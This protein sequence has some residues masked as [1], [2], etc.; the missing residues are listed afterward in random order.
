[1]ANGLRSRESWG[2]RVGVI[3][4]VTGSAVG[5][6]NFLR[7]PGLAAKYEGGAFMIPYF[8]ALLVLGLPLAWG[9]WAMG[10]FGGSRG[11]NSTPGIY[12]SIWKRK[13]APY[14]G[15]LGLV[16]PVAIYMYYV[17]VESWCLGYAWHYLDGSMA[18]LGKVARAAGDGTVAK[19]PYVDLFNHF[20][21]ATADGAAFYDEGAP[22]LWFLL[23]CVAL[24]F[25]LIYR[26]L[27]KG[28]ERFCLIAMPALVVCALIVLVRVLTLPNVELGLGFMWN[29]RTSEGGF[30][31]SLLNADMWMAATSQI[32]FS[33]SVGFGVII[34]YSSYLKHDDDIALSS[35]TS[36]AGNEFCEVALGG[37]ITIPAAFIFLGAATVTQASGSSFNLGFMT[38][39]MVF[40]SMQFGYTV[41]FLFFFLLFLA[42][43]T[44]SLSMLQPAIALLEEGLG[45][46]RRAS[47]SMLGFITL[48]GTGFVLYFSKDNLALGMF[49]FWV[50]TFFIFVLALLQTVLFGW[51]LGV[52]RG[53]EELRRGAA[54]SVPRLV[55]YMLKYVSP[56]YLLAIFGFWLYRQITT[57]EDNVFRLLS[58]SHVARMS[59]GFIVLMV[60]FF[61]LLIGQSVRRWAR[62]EQQKQEVQI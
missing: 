21:G 6:G 11:F 55:G 27:S 62:A 20:T 36:A 13:A 39:P 17:L 29:P 34:T 60:I 35:L 7:F 16:V 59:V 12:R 38:L 31:H 22:G 51:V 2:T 53:M 3:L 8:V 45:L 42:A 41:G 9:E 58:D 61:I 47:V 28:I 40:E 19:A 33:L 10:R 26:G 14:M 25:T 57:D 5:L 54:I 23:F 49:D 4:A 43:V 56:V 46:G 30:I 37:M 48:M 24:N 15:V 32:F 44:S 1:M 18:E 50:G 52:D